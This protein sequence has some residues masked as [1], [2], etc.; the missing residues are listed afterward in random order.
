LTGTEAT[1][2]VAA[3]R[4]LVHY[5]TAGA[6]AVPAADADGDLVPDFVEEVAMVGED[7]LTRFA[8][9]GFRMPESDAAIAQ[10]G[11]DGRVDL[12]LKNLSQADGNAGQDAC[13][14]GTCI[15]HATVENDYAGFGYPSVGEGIRSVVPHEL[16]HLIQY[17]YSNDQPMV[18]TEGSAVWAVEHLYADG[19]ADFERFLGGFLSRT[20]RPF[21][22][23]GGGFGDPYPYGAAL[24]PHYLELSGGVEAVVDAWTACAT[25]GFLDAIDGSLAGGLDPAWADFTRWNLFTGDRAAGGM[26]PGADAWIEAPVE[27][28]IVASDVGEPV[29]GTVQIEGLSARYVPI[30]LTVPDDW[31][32]TV[33]P[34]GRTVRAWVVPIDGDLD[35]GVELEAE[36][37]DLIAELPPTAGDQ[38]LVVTGLSR[39]TITTAIPVVVEPAPPPTDMAGGCCS[40]GE[41]EGEGAL[42]LAMLVGVLARRKR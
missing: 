30:S 27:D 23:D 41:G 39:N 11:G 6:D 38:W 2:G 42:V 12:Y 24:W 28:A 9:D 25:A 40:T 10:N 19:N 17:A 8:A 4:V 7:A 14:G 33:R 16:F 32:I 29:E 37:D 35:A 21:E 22:R 18:W 36:G 20:Y 15:G 31:R 5:T 3:G 13:S 26:Y 34:S 1:F